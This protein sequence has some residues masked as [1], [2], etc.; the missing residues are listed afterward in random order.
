[1]ETIA[2]QK[3]SGC[4]NDFIIVDNRSGHIDESRLHQLVVGA[5]RRKLSVGADGLILVENCATADFRWRFFNADGSV[6]EMCGNGARCVARFAWLNGIAGP[7]LSFQTLAGRVSAAIEGDRVRV[8][9]PEARDLALDEPL[10]AKDAMLSVS[11]IHTG[12]PHALAFVQDLAAVDV[13]NLG[14][15]IR[16]HPHYAPAG[17]NVD[18]VCCGSDGSVS[19][20]TY[21]RGVEDETLACGTGAV[22]SAI[23]AG[24]RFGLR[25]PV[26]VHTRSKAVLIINYQSESGRFFDIDMTGDA[27]LVYRGEILA[28]AWDTA[29]AG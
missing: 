14:R 26:T 13:V 16:H 22:A 4:G 11:R 25:P 9:M 6:A 3:F 19:V 20:R 29:V 10:Q 27:R 7:R 23:V 8:R 21:E 17:T 24:A 18:F 5:C 1:M 28:E 2:F 15:V 12:V